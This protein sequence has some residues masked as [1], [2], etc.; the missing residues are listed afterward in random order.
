MAI[1]LVISLVGAVLAVVGA[2]GV[3]WVDEDV[4]KFAKPEMFMGWDWWTVK[5]LVILALLCAAASGVG[6]DVARKKLFALAGLIGTA[7][8]LVFVVYTPF[9]IRGD[10]MDMVQDGGLVKET[11]IAMFYGFH[12]GFGAIAVMALGYI[13]TLGAQPILG[14]EDR[15]LRVAMLWKGKLIREKTFPEK[16]DITIGDGLRSDFVVPTKDI[17]KDLGKVFPLFKADNKGSYSVAL[18]REWKGRVNLG[19][20]LAPVSEFVKKHTGDAAGANYVPIAHGDWGVLEFG[21]IE[22]FFQFVRP[23]VIIGHRPVMAMDGAMFAATVGSMFVVGFLFTLCQFLWDPAG[24][25]EQRKVE[26]RVL[27]VEMLISQEKDEKLLE[28]GEEEDTKGKKAEGEED[29]KSVV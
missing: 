12:I 28:I 21:E 9:L 27:K 26:K 29:R 24:S 4:V 16:H 13:W 8:M 3:P 6:L 1:G 17:N 20:V 23:D 25:V 22:L 5:V 7:L 18:L 10:V 19:G 15:L 2:F 11:R 14:P